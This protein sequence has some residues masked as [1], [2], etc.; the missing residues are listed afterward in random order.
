MLRG[1]GAESQAGLITLSPSPNDLEMP[2]EDFIGESAPV[3]RFFVRCHTMIPQIK[4]TER[5]LEIAGLVERP[6]SLTLGDLGKFPRAELVCSNVPATDT[7][8]SS[9]RSLG[10]SGAL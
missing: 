4:L 9:R 7:A 3:E 8:F 10:P 1:Q 6:L 2:V 5:K